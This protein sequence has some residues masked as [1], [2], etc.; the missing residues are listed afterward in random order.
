MSVSCEK[1]RAARSSAGRWARRRTAVAARGGMEMVGR[2]SSGGLISAFCGSG[3]QGLM[4]SLEPCP[5]FYNSRNASPFFGENGFF[6]FRRWKAE[7]NRRQKMS[8]RCSVAS[9]NSF[10]FFFL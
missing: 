6:L 2:Y 3:I 9:G 7:A 10:F 1:D 8:P 4:S 5:E